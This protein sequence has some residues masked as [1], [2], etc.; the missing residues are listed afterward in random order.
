MYIIYI[1]TYIYTYIY[2]YIKSNQIK[3]IFI[4]LSQKRASK[5]YT[6]QFI[7]SWDK[8]KEPAEASLWDAG[9]INYNPN[10]ETEIQINGL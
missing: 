5:K 9:P 1:Y 6:Y 7:K 10:V 2:I 3:K 4:V 8:T